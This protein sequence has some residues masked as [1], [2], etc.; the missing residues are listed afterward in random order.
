MDNRVH[1]RV[2]RRLSVATFHHQSAEQRPHHDNRT[3]ALYAPSEL[4]RRG[5]TLVGDFSHRAF[6]AGWLADDHRAGNDH[7]PYIKGFRNTD[8]GG[9]IQWQPA[10]RGVPAPDQFFLSAT[11]EALTLCGTSRNCTFR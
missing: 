10:V 6:G 9:Q 3:V 7:L 5:H 1:L 11:S 4:L 2:R 8:A